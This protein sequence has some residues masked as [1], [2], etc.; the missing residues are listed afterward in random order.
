M[1][2][3]DGFSP[4]TREWF[5]GAFA[6][7]TAAQE[8]AWSSIARGENT[9]VVAPTGSGKTLAA[10][11]WAIDRLAVEHTAGPS[12]PAGMAA[13]A[14]AGTA[15]GVTAGTA[16]TAARQERHGGSEAGRHGERPGGRHGAR[17]G[18]KA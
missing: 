8:G 15:A 1:G 13:S 7:P 14:A 17:R 9:L 12:A 2:S 4:V 18:R 11:L 10:F 3:L 5:A 16:G 6:T